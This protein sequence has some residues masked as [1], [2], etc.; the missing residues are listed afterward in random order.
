[1]EVFHDKTAGTLRPGTPKVTHFFCETLPCCLL[2]L[3]AGRDRL[4][5]FNARSRIERYFPLPLS[6]NPTT[7]FRDTLSEINDPGFVLERLRHSHFCTS[8][9]FQL[10][11]MSEV[12]RE[13]RQMRLLVMADARSGDIGLARKH[14]CGGSLKVQ[15][16]VRQHQKKRRQN[17]GAYNSSANFGNDQ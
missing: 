1:M 16:P 6:Y 12:V 9:N 2:D 7:I 5:S 11:G 15:L 3:I 4:F 14:I 8:G 13:A 10:E 17:A